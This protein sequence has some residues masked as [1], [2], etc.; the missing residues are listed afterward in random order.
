MDMIRVNSSNVR[1]VGY[2][3]INKALFVEFIDGTIYEYSNVPKVHYDNL[4]IAGSVGS[5]LH[6]NIIKMGYAN[7]KIK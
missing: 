5:Y 3:A 4:I 7:K 6:S 2:S 1:S